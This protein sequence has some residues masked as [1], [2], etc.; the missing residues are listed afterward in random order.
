MLQNVRLDDDVNPLDL[1]SSFSSFQSLNRGTCLLLRTRFR[2]DDAYLKALALRGIWDHS[3]LLGVDESIL[4]SGFVTD[5]GML[6][7]AFG[8]YGNDPDDRYLVLN[9]PSMS[10][11]FLNKLVEACRVSKSR[12]SL[13]IDIT[14]Q[15]SQQ[16]DIEDFIDYGQQHTMR[17]GLPMWQFSF[18]DMPDVH[19]HY[20]PKDC[21]ENYPIPT[22]G[23]VYCWR[24]CAP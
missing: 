8:D 12:H 16:L 7:F 9:R 13:V 5:E 21:Y 11:Q 4:H 19:I 1:L 15:I 3:D 17:N 10:P 24:N 23:K 14:T 22:Y 2:A 6:D 18:P 20:T